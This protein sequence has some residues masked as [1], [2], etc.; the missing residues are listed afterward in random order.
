MDHES[1]PMPHC[2]SSS[3]FSLS[4]HHMNF[5]KKIA[6]AKSETTGDNVV[7]RYVLHIVRHGPAIFLAGTKKL[8]VCTFLIFGVSLFSGTTIPQ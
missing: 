5:L 1:W 2:H 6:P 4:V 3:R 8:Y 7:R